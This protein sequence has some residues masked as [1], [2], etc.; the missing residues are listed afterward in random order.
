MYNSPDQRLTITGWMNNV[1]DEEYLVYT[2]DFTASFG[3]N[4]LGYGRPQW[5]GLTASYQW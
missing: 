5:M 2:F 4:Q 1:F 3:Y